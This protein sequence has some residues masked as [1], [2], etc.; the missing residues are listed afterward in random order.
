[1][2]VGL[3]RDSAFLPIWDTGNNSI[4]ITDEHGNFSDTV[5]ALQDWGTGP[6]TLNAE[7]AVTNKI[8]SFPI[9]VMG[10]SGPLRP[11]HFRLSVN[12]LD[13]GTGDPTENSV[14]TVALTNIGD[15]LITWQAHTAASWLLFSPGSGSF[16]R[17]QSA[18]VK[19]AVDRS[20]LK[21][22]PYSAK[23]TFA[24]NG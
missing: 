17:G 20:N 22:G 16:I 9:L 8:A 6:H 4:I 23:V 15:G 7:D 24:S 12:S 21:P 10:Q 18:Q 5:P 2:K 11:A 14:K 1:T 19:I 3:T 13:L